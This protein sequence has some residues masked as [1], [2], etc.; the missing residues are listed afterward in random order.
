M[1]RTIFDR[2]HDDFRQAVRTYV[3]RTILPTRTEAAAKGSFERDV[4]LEAGR[5]GFLGPGS[6]EEHGEQPGSHAHG[7]SSMGG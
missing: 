6:S 3:E 7:Q 5:Q 4:W 2:E 1:L